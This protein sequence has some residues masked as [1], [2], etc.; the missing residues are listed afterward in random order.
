MR[1]ADLVADALGFL[2]RRGLAAVAVIG[3]SMG[4]KA[5]MAL[6]LEHP[7]RVSRLV[8]VD[9]APTRQSDGLRP[10]L[11]A[12]LAIDPA[13]CSSREDAD[14]RLAVFLSDSRLRQFL[15]TNLMR[16]PDGHL[17]W[18]VNLRTIESHLAELAGAVESPH[19]YTGPALFIRSE[20]SDHVRDVDRPT[21]ERLFPAAEIVTIAGAGH[22]VHAEAPD[23]LTEAAAS[24]LSRP[25]SPD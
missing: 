19:A 7:D 15:L 23:A 20:R 24:F 10:V 14:R 6:A 25:E 18:R 21:I 4:G 11:D 5:A 3:H 22:W 2:D 1:Y 9:I 13:G 16:A 17:A 12:M 8:V